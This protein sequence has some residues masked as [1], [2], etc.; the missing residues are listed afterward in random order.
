MPLGNFLDNLRNKVTKTLGFGGKTP[1]NTDIANATENASVV[2]I[3]YGGN[4]HKRIR[5][6]VPFAYGVNKFGNEVIRA[7]QYDG[8]TLRGVPKW[9]MFR[10][11]KIDYW[12]ETNKTAESAPDMFNYNG[13]LGLKTIYA[14]SKFANGRQTMEQEPEETKE[15]E[16]KP[17]IEPKTDTEL[18]QKEEKPIINTDQSKREDDEIEKEDE[19]K[20]FVSKLKDKISSIFNKKNKSEKLINGDG[21]EKPVI[22]DE[23][24]ENEI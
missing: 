4:E 13:D 8:D 1:S 23:D 21:G 24:E 15:K 7:F 17:I 9:K 10:T 20:G 6:I 3:A 18:A 14:I 16:E 19:K 2:K 11:D 12:R 5:T 22:D